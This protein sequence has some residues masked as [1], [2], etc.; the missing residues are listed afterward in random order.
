MSE[1]SRTLKI[2][3][4]IIILVVIFLLLSLWHSA[5]NN[6]FHSLLI[7][8]NP[9]SMEESKQ[10]DL[11]KYE[12]NLNNFLGNTTQMTLLTWLF[13]APVNKDN[14]KAE[15]GILP[16]TNVLCKGLVDNPS[17]MILF[18]HYTDS[19]YIYMPISGSTTNLLNQISRFGNNF[20]IDLE[21]N[22]QN[23]PNIYIIPNILVGRW[24]HLGLIVNGQ[25]LEVYLNS[26]LTQSIIL[27]NS[28][29][30]DE[31][32]N[33][34][35]VGP[36]NNGPIN[37]EGLKGEIA[38]LRFYPT[39]LSIKEINDIYEQGLNQG[40]VEGWAVKSSEWVGDKADRYIMPIP[41]KLK[42][43]GENVGDWTKDAA[44]KLGKNIVDSRLFQ[45]AEKGLG[46]GLTALT[47]GDL[48]NRLLY[49][50]TYKQS[51]PYL[52]NDQ[53]LL[54]MICNR[55]G[56][57]PNPLPSREVIGNDKRQCNND[58]DCFGIDR[59]NMKTYSCASKLQTSPQAPIPISSLKCVVNDSFKNN[60]SAE[61]VQMQ[62]EQC[63]SYGS[64]NCPRDVCFTT[65]ACDG[66]ILNNH[67]DIISAN[68]KKLNSRPVNSYVCNYLC[69]DD[70]N[71]NKAIY[72]KSLES[73]YSNGG[74]NFCS[75][76]NSDIS[77]NNIM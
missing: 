64:Q 52:T 2:W 23:Y 48:G 76:G 63:N 4:I 62:N 40:V 10:L 27:Q 31:F 33:T 30:T 61:Q 20:W 39:I 19:L 15:N 21:K 22:P 41:D 73:C 69:A 5:N 34:I 57:I 71:C 24:F 55:N 36:I 38:K 72:N 18:N 17:P 47:K 32:Q 65:G 9:E 58:C 11:N 26:K 67:N 56:Y 60:N 74:Q 7:I 59:C 1:I 44:Q 29:V 51:V 16:L 14:L 75:V 77:I 12:R 42:N 3:G 46:K 28:L 70:E 68:L 43:M 54:S 37:I 50:N 66:T 53:K 6:K 35:N 13:I 49:G 45:G 25:I 8:N